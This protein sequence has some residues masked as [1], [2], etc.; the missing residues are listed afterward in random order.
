MDENKNIASFQLKGSRLIQ[1]GRTREN[2][3]SEFII[4][5]IK[6]DGWKTHFVPTIWRKKILY[7][8]LRDH[9]SIWGF[10]LYGSQRARL[11]NYKEEVYAI[12]S[13]VIYD[14]LW[15]KGCSVIVNGKW[16]YDKKIDDFFKSNDIYIDYDKRGRITLEEYRSR[17]LKDT[18]KRLS[19]WQIVKKTLLRIRSLW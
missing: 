8:W 19:Y 2:K 3:T 6:K 15:V 7:K 9:E 11:W 10:E 1:E 4:N 14:Y 18:L 17:T 16:L 5:E 13:P 12:E